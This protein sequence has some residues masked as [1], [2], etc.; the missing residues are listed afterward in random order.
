MKRLPLTKDGRVFLSQRDVREL[1]LAKAAIAT[2]I[3][4]LCEKMAV[5]QEEIQKILLAGAFGT[6]LSPESACRIGL[7]PGCLSG[8]ITAIGNAA[9]EGAKA[10]A[11]NREK[12]HGSRDLAQK[13]HF[14]E[15]A[16]EPAFQA[17]YL[18]QL[19]FPNAA[20]S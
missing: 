4:M 9:G 19:N 17:A 10:A 16:A 12:L 5:R 13:V 7:I 11:L 3:L 18:R 14:L 15:L 2:G 6:Y 20:E 8:R 1:Q